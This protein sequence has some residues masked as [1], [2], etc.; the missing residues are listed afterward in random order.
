M[1]PSSPLSPASLLSAADAIIFDFDGV[2]VDSEPLHCRT[3]AETAAALD[4][5]VPDWPA[6]AAN[7]MGYDDR[8]A[9]RALYRRAGID[10]SPADLAAAVADKAARFAA[11]AEAGL[12]PEIP[13]AAD[14]VR[15]LAAA[16]P[17]ALCS[18]AL[19]TDVL[20]VLRHLR[21]EN[22]FTVLVTADDVAASKPDPASYH[23]AKTRLL[24]LHPTLQTFL[25][26]EDTPDG[27]QSARAAAI[28][29][30]ALATHASPA[31]LLAVGA[32]ATAPSLSSALR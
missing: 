1:S 27:I 14:A 25:A 22:T 2:L 7:L 4:L 8:D 29:V 10:P 31:A 18:G 24:A 6:Y 23:L 26:V 3:I 16:K 19:R 15:T 20:P 21:L 32:A 30:L 5:P 12:V 28:P 17:V 13:G 11:L 9:F